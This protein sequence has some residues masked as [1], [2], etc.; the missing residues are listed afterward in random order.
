MP[1][2]RRLYVHDWPLY[3]DL[4]LAALRD[5]PDAFGSTL[6]REAAFP[7]AEW[8]GR[9]AAAAMSARDLPLVAEEEVGHAVGLAWVRVDSA[10]PHMAT[11]YQ[12][13]VHPVAR[14]RG[15]GQQLIEAAAT[16][17]L[18]AG[19]TSLALHVALGP[20]SALEFYRHVGFAEVGA[21]SPLRPGTDLWQQG[22][23]R[24]LG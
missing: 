12:V 16:W 13:W 19:A 14:R 4:R 18:A 10:E 22:M 7:D 11:L 5:T 21:P 1:T 20:N 24:P 17:A 8:R 9:L 2:V 3:R 6:A 23:Q 15:I